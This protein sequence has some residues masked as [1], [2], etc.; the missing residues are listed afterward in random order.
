MP[1]DCVSILGHLCIQVLE[2]VRDHFL[3][4]LLITSGYRTALT[5]AEA[6]GQPNS[7]HM[8]TPD[9]AAADFLL[10]SDR[11]EMRAVF[12]W[13]RMNERLPF[14]QLI[15]EHSMSGDVVHASVNRLRPGIR[16]VLEGAVHNLTPY[17]KV[18]YVA[19]QPPSKEHS[20]V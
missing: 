17:V 14:H 13:M 10:C 9:W 20:N 8:Y 1:D 6:H 11:T 15:L 12:D 7:E 5:N 18:D 16:S 19:Y 4:A 2:P 3:A